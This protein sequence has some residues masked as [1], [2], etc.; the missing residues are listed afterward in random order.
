MILVGTLKDIEDIFLLMP[1][2]IFD[3]TVTT[4]VDFGII[5]LSVDLPKT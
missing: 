1:F 5:L 3:A 2:N 4:D